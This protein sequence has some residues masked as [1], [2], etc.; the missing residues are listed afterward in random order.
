ME[1]ENDNLEGRKWAYE[2]QQDLYMQENGQE[3]RNEAEG[4]EGHPD[5]I[6]YD[7]N[8]SQFESA[9]RRYNVSLNILKI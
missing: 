9:E 1:L 5:I 6:L 2:H 3:I 7:H 8:L 4:F